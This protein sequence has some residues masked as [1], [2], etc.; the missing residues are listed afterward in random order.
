VF[1]AP[2]T[3]S[4]VSV[5]RR[6]LSA[7]AELNG[8]VAGLRFAAPVTHVY[9]PLEYA[10]RPYR[11]YIRRFADGPKHTVF[12]G[13][14]PGPFGMAQTGVPFGAVEMVR[15]WMG[16]EAPVSR[17]PREHP[18]R[19]V[20]GFGCPRRE[21]SG[22]RLWGAVAERYGEPERFFSRHFVANYCPLVFMVESGRNLTPDKLPARERAP[23]YAACDRFLRRLVRALEPTWVIGVGAFAASRAGEALHQE[24]VRLG[25][26]LHP[27]PANPRANR[28]WAGEVETQLRQ[29]GVCDCGAAKRR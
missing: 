2:D 1:A 28:D 11:Q 12:L 29:L 22:S 15:D 13:M 23:L 21:I 16:I 25:A 6:I 9:N 3:C 24:P 7:T 17:P 26:I 20:L 18:K 8:K 27:S 10:S 19:P 14:N 4:A 5:A